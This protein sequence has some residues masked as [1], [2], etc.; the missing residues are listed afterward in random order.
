MKINSN[1][2][3][4]VMG[5]FNCK[6]ARNVPNLTGRWCVHKNSNKVGEDL[7][8]I[9]R[10]H[11]LYAISTFFQPSRKKNNATYI[12]RDKN[13]APSQIDYVLVSNRWATAFRD[14]KVKWGLSIKRW[15]RIYDHGVISCSFMSRVRSEKAQ[16]RIDFSTLRTD[17][18]VRA[19]FESEMKS[20]LSPAST[21]ATAAEL[22]SNL[23]TA[24]H[25]AASKTLPIRK[26]VPIR[27][28]NV[29]DRTRTLYEERQRRYEM[30]DVNQ[31]K[32]INRDITNSC[33]ED[34]R[35]Y[36]NRM[37]GEIEAAERVGNQREVTRITKLLTARTNASNVMPSRDLRGDPITSSDQLLDAWNEFL[38]KK[39]AMPL[40]DLHRAREHTV[41]SEESLSDKE[42]DD[43]LFA[44]KPGKAPG[45][46]EIPAEV[47]QNSATAR[48]ELYRI[49]RIIFDTEC[50]PA[51]LVRGIFIMIYKKKA[52]D[53][54]SNYR[55]ICLLCHAYKLLSAV[56]ARR[57]HIDLANVLPDTQA[58]FRP[59][60][61]TRDNICIL[62]WTIKMIL[63]EKREAVIT[64]IDYTA[65]FDTESQLFLDEALRQAG[66]S[67]K[68]RR[69]IQAI[70]SVAQGCVRQ[71]KANGSFVE[72]ELFDI[73]RGVLQ[74]DIFS[75]VAFIIGLWLIFKRHDRPNS[76]VTVGQ[77]PF[78]VHISNLEYADDAALI[79]PI[80]PVAS[81][82]LTSISD[83]S[84]TDAA[85]SI[86]FDK[87]KGM[88]IHDKVPVTETL[89]EEVI[90]MNLN[91]KCPKCSRT[92]PTL[93]GMKIHMARWCDKRR[94]PRSRKG[95]LA[96]KAVQFAKRKE[97][98]S[99][100]PPV[101]VHNH[102]IECVYFFIYLGSLIQ[103][104]GDDMADV[105]HRMNIA[106]SV[107]SALSH[108]WNDHR[109]P[110]SMKIRLYILA[111]CSTMTH[112]CESW[113][114]SASVCR[115]ING[116]NSRCLHIITG[117][118]YR[119]TATNPVFNLLLSVRKR[120]LRY[121]GHVLRMSNDRLVKKTLLA[122]THGGEHVPEGSLLM[123]CDNL[124]LPEL[125]LAAQDRKKWRRMI[126]N[127]Q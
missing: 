104:D 78:Q 5:D 52:R 118:D 121:L 92:F 59:A 99:K 38:T 9:M 13:Y 25:S 112:A 32:S 40:S 6:L 2:C 20:S 1:D 12:P 53:D 19:S 45:W 10:R 48:T 126:D 39:F 62:K 123:D 66:V 105:T 3:V 47:Y 18:T 106:Q 11:K 26:P 122:Y 100:R 60:R 86:S 74:G 98:Q 36:V 41:S 119:E 15:G 7:L 29:S 93:R 107:F 51:E 110:Q 84:T 44:M 95:T 88:H 17:E 102:L 65:A 33:R 68:V 61:G 71:R 56:L 58:G 28:R 54:F 76:G 70:F 94:R 82:R 37:I 125:E 31:R 27:K 50:I 43:A 127:L 117:K 101:T 87:T 85:M 63:R 42:L 80:V 83:G 109:L 4:I 64:F 67:V 97:E 21:P 89:E 46:D 22:Y 115:K 16:K 35:E 72:S 55:A 75:P 57:L 81:E 113:D 79:D 49:I 30:M 14:C 111:V 108:I 8:D 124:S 73:A 77:A 24:V 114:L 34:Y 23:R 90:A 96:D 116:F 103:C 69:I 91:H 120:R